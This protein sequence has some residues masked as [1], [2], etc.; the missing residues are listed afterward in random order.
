MTAN[1]AAV[2]APLRMRRGRFCEG[3]CSCRH[4]KRRVKSKKLVT[5]CARQV[6]R[7]DVELDMK[8]NARVKVSVCDLF[9]QRNRLFRRIPSRDINEL[10]CLEI[11]LSVLGMQSRVL[12]HQQ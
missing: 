4:Q 10:Q 7:I 6:S 9:N 2:C 8:I 1:G 3:R 11:F 12:D 5:F